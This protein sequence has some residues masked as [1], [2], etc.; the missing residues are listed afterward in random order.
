MRVNNIVCKSTIPPPPNMLQ[1]NFQAI[2]THVIKEKIVGLSIIYS[3]SNFALFF[4]SS[5]VHGG[6]DFIIEI[7]V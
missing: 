4:L 2:L 5:H 7:D 3:I 1:Y 6:Q